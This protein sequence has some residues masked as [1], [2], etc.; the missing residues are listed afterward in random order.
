MLGQ[1]SGLAFPV[2]ALTNLRRNRARQCI[3]QE[4][5]CWKTILMFLNALEIMEGF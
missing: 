1:A 2:G 5:F 4:Y 3:Q